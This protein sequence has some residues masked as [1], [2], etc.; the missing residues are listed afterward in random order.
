MNFCHENFTLG[1]VYLHRKNVATAKR[2]LFPEDTVLLSKMAPTP[3]WGWE[4]GLQKTILAPA[5]KSKTNFFDDN[6]VIKRAICTA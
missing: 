2:K 6:P 3:G 5:K 4:G 1:Q